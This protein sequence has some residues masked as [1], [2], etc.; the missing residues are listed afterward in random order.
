MY[1]GKNIRYLRKK[2]KIKQADLAEK[3]GRTRTAISNLENDVHTPTLTIAIELSKIF[4]IFIDDLQVFYISKQ[5]IIYK[6]I[7]HFY[8]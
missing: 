4:D 8:R 2:R 3:L 6:N 7:R 1:I 5:K